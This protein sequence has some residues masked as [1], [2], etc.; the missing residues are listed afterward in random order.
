MEL[1]REGNYGVFVKSLGWE[2]KVIVIERRRGDVSDLR[3]GTWNYLVYLLE[4]AAF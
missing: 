3:E 4:V 2:G 1:D